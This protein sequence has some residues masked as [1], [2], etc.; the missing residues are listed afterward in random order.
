MLISSLQRSDDPRILEPFF[1][2]AAA[3]ERS[4]PE[5]RLGLFVRRRSSVSSPNPDAM[6]NLVSGWPQMSMKR[7]QWP[8]IVTF[9]RALT[10][11]GTAAAKQLYCG[12]LG[13]GPAAE[14]EVLW[15]MR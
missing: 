5:L 13:R 12:Q 9:G 4:V 14:E 6:C 1:P 3:R 15:N 10:S 7:W 8:E 2:A 11:Q